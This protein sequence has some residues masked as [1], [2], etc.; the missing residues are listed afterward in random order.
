MAGEDPPKAESLLTATD[1]SGDHGGGDLHCLRVRTV[2]EKPDDVRLRMPSTDEVGDR[3]RWPAGVEGT[4][5]HGGAGCP[6]QG[7][8]PEAGKYSCDV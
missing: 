4:N 6:Q 7:W 2:L 8:R 5:S 1:G 3:R